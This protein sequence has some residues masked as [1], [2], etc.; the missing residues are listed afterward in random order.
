MILLSVRTNV[1]MGTNSEFTSPIHV[2]Y[3]VPKTGYIV[4]T[5]VIAVIPRLMNCDLWYIYMILHILYNNNNYI[6]YT[7]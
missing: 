5:T 3:L 6:I 2:F 1:T 7:L 4:L